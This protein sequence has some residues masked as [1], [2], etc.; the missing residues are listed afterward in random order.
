VSQPKPAG[1]RVA[2]THSGD[3]VP[4][5]Q[6]LFSTLMVGGQARAGWRHVPRRPS[7]PAEAPLRV[8]VQPAPEKLVGYHAWTSTS[9]PERE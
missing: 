3:G 5:V 4:L 9:Q 8:G 6:Q 7:D 2:V 1:D